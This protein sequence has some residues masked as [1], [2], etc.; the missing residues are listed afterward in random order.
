MTCEPRV[1]K[2]LGIQA[3]N[4]KM[5]SPALLEPRFSWKAQMRKQVRTEVLCLCWNFNSNGRESLTKKRSYFSKTLKE[6]VEEGHADGKRIPG[7]GAVRP[8]AGRCKRLCGWDRGREDRRTESEL[9]KVAVPGPVDGGKTG[10]L[11]RAWRLLP[12]RCPPCR[13]TGSHQ[14]VLSREVTVLWPSF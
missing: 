2:R 9:T 6:V 7:E 8:D 12:Q 10:S 11:A 4:K 3:V 5:E 1:W 13:N 14:D